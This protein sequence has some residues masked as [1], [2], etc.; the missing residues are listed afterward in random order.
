MENKSTV[1]PVSV[2]SY[3]SLP[4]EMWNSVMTIEN[5]PIRHIQKL[6]PMA[7]HAIFQILAYMWSAIFA[8]YIGSIYAFGISGA[9]HSLIIGGIFITGM[10][11]KEAEKRSINPTD[12]YNGRMR[13]G[14]H[15]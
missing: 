7:A 8:L 12:G 15:E 6:D 10:S 9:F 1:V 4:K 2:Q 5:S 3:I 11:Y 14:E 13:G